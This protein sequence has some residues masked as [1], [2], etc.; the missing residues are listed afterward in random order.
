VIVMKYTTPRRPVDVERAFP[1]LRGQVRSAV[2]LHP[3][4]GSPGQSDS[5]MGGELWWPAAEEWPECE[6]HPLPMPMVPV[7]QLWARDVPRLVMRPGTDVVQMLWCP[8]MH[9]IWSDSDYGPRVRL[10]WRDS[11]EAGSL[12]TSRPPVQDRMLPHLL[13]RPCTVYP[14]EIS[15]YPR[16]SDVEPDQRELAGF[17]DDVD[18]WS[19]SS[20]LSCAPGAKVGGWPSW[21][22]DPDWPECAVG[23]RMEH[24]LTVATFEFDAV[25]WRAW[26]PVEDLVV[27]G[28]GSSQ[29]AQSRDDVGPGILLGD[30]GKL[31]LFICRRCED[32]PIA[33]RVQS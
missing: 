27:A 26:V 1:F 23:H 20:H 29:P 15:E 2:R 17:R 13:L 22:Q 33:K 3:R 8:H 19:Y 7:L 24:L 12:A 18:G 6:A 9:D 16:M 21:H 10:Y 14:E 5:S 4:V 28:D 30:G 25:S 11:T 32:W 31:F